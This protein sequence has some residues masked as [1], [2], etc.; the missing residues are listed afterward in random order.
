MSTTTMNISL[1]EQLKKKIQSRITKG[2]FSTPSD[3]VR[4]L[5]R[6]DLSKQEE[7]L[8]LARLIQEGIDSGMS[9]KT[10]EQLFSEIRNRIK[11]KST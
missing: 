3:Y 6:E 10:T 7:Q 2:D 4:H 11:R 1:P 9:D 8:E 5:V